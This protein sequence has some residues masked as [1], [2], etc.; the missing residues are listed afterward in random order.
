MS[1]ALVPIQ[2][3]LPAI[4]QGQK[5]GG[6]LTTGVVEGFPTISYRG[7]VWRIAALST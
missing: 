4:F 3:A 7:K 1:N 5:T 6:D 2:G